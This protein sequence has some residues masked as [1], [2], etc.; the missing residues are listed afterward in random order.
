MSANVNSR[1]TLLIV[2]SNRALLDRLARHFSARGFAVTATHHPRQ[3][4]A[5]A[6]QRNYEQLLV[7]STMPEVGGL[8]LCQML[9]RS[10]KDAHLVLLSDFSD[11]ALRNEALEAGVDVVLA[12]PCRLSELDEHLAPVEIPS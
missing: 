3:A 12:S 8:R 7:G 10:L 1:P 11:V 6:T 2:E 4:V 9:R 5:S